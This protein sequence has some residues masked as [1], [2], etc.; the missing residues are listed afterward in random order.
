MK[1]SNKNK[2]I[3]TDVES[4][5]L[6]GAVKQVK[7]ICYKARKEEGMH[8]A[9]KVDDGFEHFSRSYSEKGMIAEE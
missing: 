8:V 2:Q 4:A 9:G 3:K 5:G 1:A 7:Q 6:L